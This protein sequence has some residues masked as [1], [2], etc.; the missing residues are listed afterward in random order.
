MEKPA[1]KKTQ[2]IRRFLPRADSKD[3]LLKVLSLCLGALLWYLVVGEDQVDMNIEVPIEVLNLPESL[4]I[5]NQ[6]KKELDVTIRG[7][8][9]LIQEL[10]NR[11]ISRP[12]DLSQAVPGTIIIKN[13]KDSIPLPRGISILQLQPANI[14]LSI[15]QLVQ[16][17]IPI[18]A[19]TEGQVAEGYTLKRITLDPDKIIVSGPKKVIDSELAFKTYVINLDKLDHS[20]T[21]PVNLNLTPEF[22]NLI[23]ETVVVATIEVQ[24]NFVTKTVT[25]IPINVKDAGKPVTI[26]PDTIT[27]VAEIPQNLVR[28]TPVPAMLFRAYI[29]AKDIKKP[30]TVPVI[31]NG[32]NVPGHEPIVI[33][34]HTPTRVEVIPAQEHLKKDQSSTEKEGK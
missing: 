12:I 24:E 16:K 18:H 1:Q 17:T 11:N 34:S 7:P 29:N 2:L 9:S 10:R 3:L 25:G 21:L 23:G 5:A 27:V 32:V 15:D 31:V 28:D 33:K 4:V 26:R 19:V 13:D 6:Y 8:R 14:T 20:T 22:I 30:K